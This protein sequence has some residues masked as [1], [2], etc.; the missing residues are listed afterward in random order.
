MIDNATIVISTVLVVYVIWQAVRLD[1]LL[2]WFES[3]SMYDKAKGQEG[4]VVET[5]PASGR[6][7]RR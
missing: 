4:K 2:P 1:K 7:F 3:R 6:L 5:K